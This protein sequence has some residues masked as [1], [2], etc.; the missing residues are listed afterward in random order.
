MPASP[1]AL[2][3]RRVEGE[4]LGIEA[5][6]DSAGQHLAQVTSLTPIQHRGEVGVWVT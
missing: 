3:V 5:V 1:G 2:C 4:S 6:V